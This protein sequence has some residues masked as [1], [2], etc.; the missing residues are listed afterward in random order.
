[1]CMF[2]QATSFCVANGSWATPNDSFYSLNRLPVCYLSVT[3]LLQDRFTRQAYKI[4]IEKCSY[5]TCYGF[6]LLIIIDCY[7]NGC[8]H[9]Y[10]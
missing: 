4:E 9:D 2:Y 10:L 8:M 7:D 3:C 6:D 1:M 5:P